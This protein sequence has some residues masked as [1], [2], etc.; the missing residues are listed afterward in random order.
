[1]SQDPNRSDNPLDAY[2][3]DLEQPQ[4]SSTGFVGFLIP[5]VLVLG[6]GGGGLFLYKGK[7]DTNEYVNKK[8]VEARDKVKKHDLV[9]LKIAEKLFEEAY[10]KDPENG[11]TQA[12]LAVTYYHMSEHGLDTLGKAKDFIA[13]AEAQDTQSGDRY[14]TRGYI[15]VAEGRAEKAEADIKK[16]LEQDIAAPRIAHALGVAL[17]QQN[18][19]LEANRVLRQATET[20]FSAVAYKLT[21]ADVAHRSGDER[22]AA[23]TLATIL[24]SN[25][26]PGHQQAA[27]WE[28]ALRLKNYG[29]LVRPS[30]LVEQVEKAK[31]DIGP[32]TQAFLM[33]AKG[34]FDLAT[35]NPDK[36]IEKAD[37]ALKAIPDY[38]PFLDLKARAYVSKGKFDEA[39][40]E[41]EKAT[42][43]EG[44]RGIKW[45]LARLKSKR[46]DDA[47]LVIVDKLEKT[48]QGTKG[49]EYK[50]FRAEHAFG[51]GDLEQAKK[52]FTEAA[53][54][55][56]D[57]KI[58][59][60]LAKI[61]FEEEKAKKNKADLD[62]VGKALS[63]ALDAKSTF[64]EVYE[65]LA[66]IS[67]WNYIVDGANGEFE[68]AE[69][70]Y[71]K[72]RRP[73]PEVIG[74]YDRVINSFATLDAPKK[75]KRQAKKYAKAWAEKKGEY[76]AS[77]AKGES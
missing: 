16:L 12:G 40:V 75:V 43:A 76:L 1:M 37:K 21:L 42:A 24:R 4:G 15:D 6:L 59:F 66:G 48:H 61:T 65:Y 53:D 26:N 69:K 23:K 63:L 49:P 54:M 55:G 10:A 67:L 41:Y 68:T 3:D 74:F 19:Y 7:V 50:M 25:M 51:K 44:Y 39:L 64:P 34:E 77:V 9:N 47:A 58:L 2:A 22:S 62:K 13:K 32:R 60:G 35:F 31:D 8:L 38:P 70:Q 28:A 30:K 45:D 72:Q 33:W 5:V 56:D 20:D 52:L 57:P 36:A 27:A 14:A 11:R 71:K 73:I 17:G 29:N 46:K 18:K